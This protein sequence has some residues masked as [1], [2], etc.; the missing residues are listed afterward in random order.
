MHSLPTD[1]AGI[2][3]R[4]VYVDVF[5]HKIMYLSVSRMFIVFPR[6]DPFYIMHHT[7]HAQRVGSFISAII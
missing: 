4:C 2:F 7:P 5:L 6:C 1:P 3:I